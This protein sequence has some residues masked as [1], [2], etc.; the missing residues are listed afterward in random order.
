MPVACCRTKKT[1]LLYITGTKVATLPHEAVT[2]IQ[3]STLAD[4]LNKY[5]THSLSVWACILLD[6]ADKSLAF[7]QKQLC[8]LGNFF[9]MHLCNTKAI[10]DK[11]LSALHL[12]SSDIMTLINI[13]A[14]NVAGLTATM[15][16]LDVT[17]DGT[18]DDQMGDNIDEMD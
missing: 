17:N 15:S 4:D 2:K 18:T 1:P 13:P 10:Q 16:D 5:S 12:A 11:H 14:E 3:P 9:K 6:E 7:I 8:W